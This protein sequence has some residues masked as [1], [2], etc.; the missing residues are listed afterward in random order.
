M[1]NLILSAAFAGLQPAPER[2]AEN[3]E[4][5]RQY[6]ELSRPGTGIPAG[7]IE[8][9]ELFWYGCPHCYQFEPTLNPWIET[10][11]AD[12]NFIAYPGAVRRHLG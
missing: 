11:P 12:V 4:A 5:G 10:L 6:E 2:R 9:V 3:I 1:R 8:V 7:R